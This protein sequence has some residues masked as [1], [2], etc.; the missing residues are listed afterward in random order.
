MRVSAYALNW[1]KIKL[2]L[3][4]YTLFAH[5]KESKQ[6]KKQKNTQKKEEKKRKEKKETKNK[7]KNTTQK[8]GNQPVMIILWEAKNAFKSF[9]PV[10]N[11]CCDFFFSLKKEQK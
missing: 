7:N 1:N 2:L 9:M 11:D 6:K 5:I 3:L 10:I 8:A 4:Y